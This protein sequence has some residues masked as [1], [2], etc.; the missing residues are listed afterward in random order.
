LIDNPEQAIHWAI[1]QQVDIINLS[2]VLF[3]HDESLRR[4]IERAEA[5]GILIICSTADQ[6]YTRQ[7]VWPAKYSKTN[8]N[9]FRCIFPIA[10]CNAH[11][12][13]TEYSSEIDAHYTF[14]G[15]DVIASSAKGAFMEMQSSVSGSS[16]ATAMATG[17]ASLVLAC[18]RILKLAPFEHRKKGLSSIPSVIIRNVF[19]KMCRDQVLANAKQPWY[20]KPWCVFPARDKREGSVDPADY[21]LGEAEDV[22][23][24]IVEVFQNGMLSSPARINRG[25]YSQ[26]DRS[27][28]GLRQ[29]G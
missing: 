14:R 6:G 11:G 3:V 12:K 20:V 10:A 25:L 5:A 21:T 27:G 17:V 24:W 18:H 23:Q 9:E 7:D 15:E 22:V 13:L 4:A 1:D 28:G 19:A 26:L 16:V 2:L 29:D 8:S